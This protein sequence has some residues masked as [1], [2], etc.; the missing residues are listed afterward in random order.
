M[1]DVFYIYFTWM[2]NFYEIYVQL[3]VNET[4]N[5]HQLRG[6]SSSIFFRY[7]KA[8]A[9]EFLENLE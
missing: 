4:I 5:L 6:I 8:N 3:F 2:D 9:S 1:V 7:S